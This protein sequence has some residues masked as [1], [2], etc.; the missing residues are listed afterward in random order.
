MTAGTNEDSK[1]AWL[2][3][4]TQYASYIRKVLIHWYNSK[5]ISL[6]NIGVGEEHVPQRNYVS[7]TTKPQA[8]I[9][10]RGKTSK[11]PVITLSDSSD[12]D[13]LDHLV[14]LVREDIENEERQEM[15]SN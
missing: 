6:S 15:V 14:N 1:Y 4:P 5:V 11:A 2:K 13:D 7:N 12:E 9:R 8:I 10:P 3:H